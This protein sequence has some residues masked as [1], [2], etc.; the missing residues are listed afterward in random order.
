MCIFRKRSLFIEDIARD[1]DVV[2][3]PT[4][5]GRK[6]AGGAVVGLKGVLALLLLLLFLKAFLT[7]AKKKTQAVHG[8]LEKILLQG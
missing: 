2:M 6:G 7:R 8:G 5:Q 3:T 4:V 1:I